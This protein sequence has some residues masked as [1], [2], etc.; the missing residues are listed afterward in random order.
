MCHAKILGFCIIGTG[1]PWQVFKAAYQGDRI[2]ILERKVLLAVEDGLIY[3]D[4]KLEWENL[5]GGFGN[6]TKP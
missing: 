2:S 5:S 3:R 4:E 6:V 1:V